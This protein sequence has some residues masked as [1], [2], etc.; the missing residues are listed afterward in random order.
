[1]SLASLRVYLSSNYKQSKQYFAAVPREHSAKFG[2]ESIYDEE[3]RPYVNI[4]DTWLVL[5]PTW[6]QEFGEEFTVVGDTSQPVNCSLQTLGLAKGFAKEYDT[7]SKRGN[8][9][10]WRITVG[11][12][13]ISEVIALY[14]HIAQLEE[15]TVVIA[16]TVSTNRRTG[17][18]LRPC[19]KH[20]HAFGPSCY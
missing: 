19:R 16:K 9:Q 17:I 15:V 6:V 11:G 20:G 1:M 2:G 5:L 7:G 13:V 12:K 14:K 10:A 4:H 8:W 3:S 18:R